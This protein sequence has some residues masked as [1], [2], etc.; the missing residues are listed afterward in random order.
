MATPTLKPV[1]TPERAT[2]GRLGPPIPLRAGP[3]PLRGGLL[4]FLR[5]ARE[6]RMLTPG[7][8]LLMARWVW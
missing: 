8:L 4:T 3:P 7:H 6:H 2:V 1:P 5:F